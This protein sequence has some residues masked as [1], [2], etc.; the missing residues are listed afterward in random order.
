MTVT[1]AQ[2]RRWRLFVRRKN[3]MQHSSVQ[4]QVDLGAFQKGFA[5]S[6]CLAAWKKVGAATPEGVT[7]ACLD[8]VQVLKSLGDGDNIDQLHWSIQAANDI[9]I[10]ALTQGGYDAQWLRATLVKV[11]EERPITQPNM[12]ERQQ[13]LAEVHSHSGR[14]HVTGGMHITANDFFISQERIVQHVPRWRRRRNC[15]RNSN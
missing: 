15:D 13:A 14:F 10:H 1:A 2:L 7:R 5:R 11:E 3:T 6:R 12:L 9:A 8:D 4:L